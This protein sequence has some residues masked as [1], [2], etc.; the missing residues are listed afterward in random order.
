MLTSLNRN[1][2]SFTYFETIS[3]FARLSSDGEWNELVIKSHTFLPPSSV[4]NKLVI[5]VSL[6]LSDL[7]VDISSYSV[8]F[9]VTKLV[10]SSSI[11]SYNIHSVSV[12]S[13]NNCVL[14]YFKL[15]VSL[16]LQ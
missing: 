8:F 14:S 9:S 4:A 12:S 2:W 15:T 3:I 1:S 5:C 7:F 16:S 11:C 13:T 6:I 10:L